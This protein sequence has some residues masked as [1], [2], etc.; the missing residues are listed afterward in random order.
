[1]I[2]RVDALSLFLHPHD[3]NETYKIY[4]EAFRRKVN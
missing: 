3:E 1:M 2:W 4:E